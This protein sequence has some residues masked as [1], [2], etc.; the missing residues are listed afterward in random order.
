MGRQKDG[1]PDRIFKGPLTL[2]TG[3][4]NLATAKIRYGRKFRADI[5]IKRLFRPS[6]GQE[7]HRDAGCHEKVAFSPDSEVI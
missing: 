6:P 2:G 4:E 3:R 5:H 1:Q 7:F